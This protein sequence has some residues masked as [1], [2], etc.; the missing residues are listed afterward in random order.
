MKFSLNDD[1][2]DDDDGELVGDNSALYDN[3]K[4]M[5][6]DYNVEKVNDT[7]LEIASTI[8]EVKNLYN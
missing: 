1:I 2:D 3:K 6:D 5:N 8:I 7:L 4:D